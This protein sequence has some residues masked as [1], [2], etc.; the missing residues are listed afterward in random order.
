MDYYDCFVQI[1][2]FVVC[3]DSLFDCLFDTPLTQCGGHLA[4]NKIDQ[5]TKEECHN[6][7]AREI[8]CWDEEV[9]KEGGGLMN[10]LQVQPSGGGGLVFLK[11]WF[12]FLC[13]LQQVLILYGFDFVCCS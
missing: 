5:K 8:C 10:D 9:R 11:W 4:T 2:R 6:M 12:F 13:K 3:S 1:F 7:N